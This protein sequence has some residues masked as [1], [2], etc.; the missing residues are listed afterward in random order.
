MWVTHFLNIRLECYNTLCTDDDHWLTI[1]WIDP[2]VLRFLCLLL[3]SLRSNGYIGDLRN[4]VQVMVTI[5]TSLVVWITQD[6]NLVRPLAMM[7]GLLH[8]GTNVVQQVPWDRANPTKKGLSA[9]IDYMELNYD[10][11][12]LN[13]YILYL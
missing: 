10:M 9:W 1:I 6:L 5:T 12:T 11:F 3:F 2:M 7:V 8:R 13:F 4:Y